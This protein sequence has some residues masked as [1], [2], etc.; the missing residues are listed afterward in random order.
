MLSI[1]RRKEEAVNIYKCDCCGKIFDDEDC[2]DNYLGC[3]CKVLRTSVNQDFH[4]EDYDWGMHLCAECDMK[5]E[6][7]KRAIKDGQVK[8]TKKNNLK[9][10]KKGK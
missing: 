6:V 5:F 1:R 3:C 8:I 7:L 2:S 9:I 4:K 10:K